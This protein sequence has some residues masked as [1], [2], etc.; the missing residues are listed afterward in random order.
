MKSLTRR[1]IAVTLVVFFCIMNTFLVITAIEA[2]LTM[3]SVGAL[4]ELVGI[5]VGFY[6]MATVAKKEEQNQ[7]ELAAIIRA[8]LE[9]VLKE[10]TR[11]P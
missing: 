9:E 4:I 6:F 3:L 8:Q 11:I 5:V 2:E 1:W 7:E 10:R